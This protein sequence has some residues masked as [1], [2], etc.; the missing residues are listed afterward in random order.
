MPGANDPDCRRLMRFGGEKDSM[1]GSEKKHLSM[2]KELLQLR[3][4][5]MCLQYGDCKV[6]TI[7]PT[8]LVIERSYFRSKIQFIFNTS[9]Q[10]FDL[11]KYMFDVETKQSFSRVLSNGGEIPKQLG[12][13]SFIVLKTN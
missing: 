2:V 8:V 9:D 4:T 6:F 5:E 7:S 10:N 11:E 13:E 1:N 3:K 12:G